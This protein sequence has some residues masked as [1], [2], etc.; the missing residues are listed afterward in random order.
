MASTAPDFYSL[1]PQSLQI[2]RGKIVSAFPAI[3][4]YQV[5]LATS[6]TVYA[7]ALYS[8]G[9][10][11][12]RPLTYHTTTY[13]IGT[14]VWVAVD[15]VYHRAGVILGTAPGYSPARIENFVLLGYPFVGGFTFTK[16]GPG[17]TLEARMYASTRDAHRLPLRHHG[18]ADLAEGTF[19]WMNALGGGV[20]LEPLRSVISADA[21]TGIDLSAL[22]HAVSIYGQFIHFDTL[23]VEK[24][25]GSAGL[26]GYQHEFSYAIPADALLGKQPTRIVLSGLVYTG[27]HDAITYRTD[28]TENQ[29]DSSQSNASSHVARSAL[30]HEYRGVDGTY[31]LT[32][33]G[34]ITLQRY[35]GIIVPHYVPLQE[36]D[37]VAIADFPRIKELVGTEA[38]AA[39]HGRQFL[40]PSKPTRASPTCNIK[41]VSVPEDAT[42]RS[43]GQSLGASPGSS[44]F[45]QEQIEQYKS[46]LWALNSHNYILA[47]LGA[48]A[49][50]AQLQSGIWRF[51]SNRL[52]K[53]FYEQQGSQKVLRRIDVYDLKDAR[54]WKHPPKAFVLKID[55]FGTNK[56]FYTGKAMISLTPDGGVIIQDAWGSQIILSGG[57]IFISAERDIILQPGRDLLAMVGR[58]TG[59]MSH[60]NIEIS[61][62][63]GRAA[64]VASSMLNLVGGLST[65]GG[66]AIT[67][68]GINNGGI[69]ALHGSQHN[70]GIIL[71][72]AGDISAKAEHSIHFA[73][74]NGG[75]TAIA[76]RG[77]DLRIA[78][79][80]MALN[81]GSEA[82]TVYNDNGAT[83]LTG[84]AIATKTLSA[85]YVSSFSQ[86]IYIKPAAV[87]MA[88][89]NAVSPASYYNNRMPFDYTIHSADVIQSAVDFGCTV[90]RSPAQCLPIAKW[91]EMSITAEQQSLESNIELLYKGKWDIPSYAAIPAP[92]AS[93]NS[94]LMTNNLYTHMGSEYNPVLADAF[95][96]TF[97]AP[98]ILPMNILPR[99]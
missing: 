10:N 70:P 9:S 63:S 6:G 71:S 35:A 77:M 13:S 40:D 79:R 33:A 99:G 46:L 8:G 52:P 68:H 45:E 37:R 5:Q 90:Y 32:A 95:V 69:Y 80:N 67:S 91:Q 26:T 12:F 50:G 53:H 86:A 88:H 43:P 20:A 84:D 76:P 41:F 42:D 22:L 55:P 25:I 47:V 89:N 49:I 97:T 3:G 58:D 36:A 61:A 64:L 19:A 83:Y 66:V 82:I 73:A 94:V 11:V 78:G 59:M 30:I 75:L 7:T 16:D 21:I 93:I 54:Q 17:D 62:L 98:F 72:S 24:E 15:P 96:G 1:V 57:N 44:Y 38:A 60:R 27:A 34:S 4:V 23:A 28:Q 48:Q 74:A 18:I 85:L 56:T 2:V 39:A 31:I 92:F 14:H 65:S 51:D 87:D 81:I 29:Q